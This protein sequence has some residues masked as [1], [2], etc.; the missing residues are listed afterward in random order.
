MYVKPLGVNRLPCQ[1]CGTWLYFPTAAAVPGYPS[2]FSPPLFV[3]TS[4]Q[5]LS[6]TPTEACP[7]CQAALGHLLTLYQSDHCLSCAPTS[8]TP[9]SFCVCLCVCPQTRLIGAWLPL[10]PPAFQTQWRGEGHG[11]VCWGRDKP[12]PPLTVVRSQLCLLLMDTRS[13]G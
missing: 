3:T 1:C 2:L 8:P 11:A 13:M 12:P 9:L 7:P 6:L 5:T 4:L 10:P